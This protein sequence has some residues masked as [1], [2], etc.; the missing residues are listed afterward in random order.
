MINTKLWVDGWVRSI[1]PLDRLLFVYLLTNEHTNISGIYELSL[2]VMAFEVGLNAK[3]ITTAFMPRLAPKVYYQDGW[4]ILPNFPKHQNLKSNDVK[5]GIK[6]EFNNAPITAQ[7][8]A[9]SAGW[10]D[11]LGIVP[12]PS[13]DHPRLPQVPNLTKP[14]LLAS[15]D[16]KSSKKKL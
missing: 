10:G 14:N 2:D 12:P 11:G 9:I 8:L 1:N 4:V 13:L 3:D 16:A 6:R 5:E 7:T 15:E